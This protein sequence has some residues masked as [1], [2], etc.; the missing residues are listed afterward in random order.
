MRCPKCG[1][2]YNEEIGKCPICGNNPQE[3]IENLIEQTK[4]QYVK[5]E[6]VTPKK[7]G[8]QQNLQS[9]G[10]PEQNTDAVTEKAEEYGDSFEQGSE[11]EKIP[12]RLKEYG[13]FEAEQKKKRKV[14]LGVKILICIL[15]ILA[16]AV[17]AMFATNMLSV[18]DGKFTFNPNVLSSTVQTEKIPETTPKGEKVT[19]PNGNVV[20]REPATNPNGETATDPQGNVI[21]LEPATDPQGN[22]RFTE[23]GEVIYVEPAT[24]PK[25]NVVA[26]APSGNSSSGSSSGAGNNNS[27]NG[28]GSQNN[29]SNNSSNNPS[30]NSSGNS[31]QTGSQSSQSIPSSS[32]SSSS[33]QSSSNTSSKPE[34]NSSSNAEESTSVQINGKTFEVGDR[35]V[36]TAYL[37]EVN[38]TV[39]AINASVSYNSS[40]LKID[41]DTIRFPEISPAT[42]NDKLKDELLFNASD[43]G[44]YSF[45]QENIVVTAEFVITKSSSTASEINLNFN[46]LV[47]YDGKDIEPGQVRQTVEKV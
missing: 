11:E 2:E 18:K 21:Y 22:I 46:E 9:D 45:A 19:D 28:T 25:G 13:E 40:M 5:T 14:P 4:S 44:G 6:E 3:E 39:C 30:N 20:Y 32:N 33:S 43:L 15:I 37:S 31:S 23:S 26:A 10:I 41:S 38:T 34:S 24:D 35:I 29:S 12:E 47:D 27:S 17:G 36:Y 42:Y 7:A 1:N 8:I 16:I